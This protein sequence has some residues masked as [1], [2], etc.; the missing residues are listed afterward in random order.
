MT[1][2]HKDQMSEWLSHPRPGA[3]RCRT[4]TPDDPTHL[5]DN[6]VI[7]RLECLGGC[8][9]VE[10]VGVND[11]VINLRGCDTGRG[12]GHRDG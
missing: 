2:N 5:Q 3:Q 8:L 9:F 10:H 1:A 6:G 7:G 4:V 12:G 11:S